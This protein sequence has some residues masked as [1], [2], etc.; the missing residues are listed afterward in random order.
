MDIIDAIVQ[1]EELTEWS[2][3]LTERQFNVI[4]YQSEGLTYQDIAVMLGLTWRQVKRDVHQIRKLVRELVK[5]G[6]T[7]HPL[8]NRL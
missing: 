3:R 4:L 2:D 5:R 6:G 8:E 7:I 1:D